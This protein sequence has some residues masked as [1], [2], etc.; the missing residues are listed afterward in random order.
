MLSSLAYTLLETIRR[1]GLTGTEMARAQAGAIRL[2]RLEIG[3]V[4]PRNSRRVR[5]RLSSACPDKA[6]FMLAAE[7]LTPG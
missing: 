5:F 6:R 4:I 7:R 3:A 2:K 1:I